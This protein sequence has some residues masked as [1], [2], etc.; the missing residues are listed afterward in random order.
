[1]F[2]RAKKGRREFKETLFSVPLPCGARIV[3]TL[4]YVSENKQ[5]QKRCV[6]LQA[7]HLL[8]CLLCLCAAKKRC[9]MEGLVGREIK[10]N[11]SC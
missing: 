11:K 9:E 3:G 1:M 8:G 10:G 4:I 5:L 7:G 6:L 2:T